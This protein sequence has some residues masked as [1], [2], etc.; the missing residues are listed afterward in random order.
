MNSAP[1]VTAIVIV[2]NG[3]RFIG[4]ALASIAAQDYS[5][6]ETIVVDGASTDRTERIVRSFDGVRWLPQP[7]RGVS[8]AYNTGIAAARGEFIAFLSHDDVWTE[9]KTSTQVQALTA[10]PEIEYATGMAA[11]FLEPGFAMPSGFRTELLEGGH[12]A[13]IMETLTARPSVFS[14]VG[15]LLETLSTAEDVDWFARARHLGVA[16]VEIPKILVRKRI[17]DANASL[18]THANSRNLLSALRL[19]VSRKRI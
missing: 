17:H 6:I 2:R 12:A 18:F 3:E 15:P 16:H 10:R 9:D 8:D 19:S 5:P 1:L 14:R 11:F 7:R 4:E 13:S